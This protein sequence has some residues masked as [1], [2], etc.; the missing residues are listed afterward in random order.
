VSAP[1][2]LL[3]RLADA[4]DA[5]VCEVKRI[6][7]DL[8]PTVLDQLGLVGAITE[9]AR[10]VDEVVQIHLE[11][12]DEAIRLPAAVEVAMYRIVAEALTN[13]VRHAGASTCWVTIIAARS[14]E[15]DVVDDGVGFT[16]GSS[17]GIG[18]VGMLE[19]SAELGGTMTISSFA[20]HGTRVHVHL[21]A[22]LP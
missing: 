14:V 13:V 21:P 1:L 17:A 4:V 19:R 16:P 10:T 20:P 15:I 22:V 7:R 12:P 9:F 3:S 18:L 2:G 6:L 11:L 8:R 5:T